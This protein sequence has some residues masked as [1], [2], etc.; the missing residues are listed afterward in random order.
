MTTMTTPNGT[1]ADTAPAAA[2]A[3][4][5]LVDLSPAEAK[6]RIDAGAALIDVR[7]PDEHRRECIP[8]AVN[9]PLSTL[10]DAAVKGAMSAASADRAIFHCQGGVRSAQAARKLLDAG[11]PAAEHLEGGLGAWKKAGLPTRVNRKAPISVMRQVQLVIGSMV[12]LFTAL[13]AFA[14]PWFLIG[15]AFFGA[16]LT[17]A[18]ATGTCALA[19]MLAKMPWNRTP[20]AT[21]AA[22]TV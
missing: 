10:T 12:L 16:G 14:S 9:I 20:G 22:C 18:G 19:S 17:F 11:W 15:P 2:G 7:E 3:A 6:R 13:G 5:G 4:A 8:G 21:G 1:P